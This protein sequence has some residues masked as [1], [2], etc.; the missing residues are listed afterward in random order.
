MLKAK[1]VKFLDQKIDSTKERVRHYLSSADPQP[2]VTGGMRME[3]ECFEELRAMID[4][5]EDGPTGDQELDL[6]KKSR[7]EKEAA[8][9]AQIKDGPKRTWVRKNP[10]KVTAKA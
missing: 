7:E 6:A 10:Y 5:V 1:V 3:L 9:H 4:L 8:R 2:T